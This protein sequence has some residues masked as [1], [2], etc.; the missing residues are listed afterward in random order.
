[1]LKWKRGGEGS[2]GEGGRRQKGTS[3]HILAERGN[4]VVLKKG[5]LLYTEKKGQRAT[6]RRRRSISGK[7]ERPLRGKGEA[8]CYRKENLKE[9]RRLD[10]WGVGGGGRLG[11]R[12]KKKKKRGVRGGREGLPGE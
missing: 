5:E 11:G 2:Q 3:Q 9:T 10:S 4:T 12:K 7:R 6:R 8:A 1:L